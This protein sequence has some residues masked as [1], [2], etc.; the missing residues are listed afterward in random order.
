MAYDERLPQIF[1]ELAD[2]LVDDFDLIDFLVLLAERS[3]DLLGSTAVGVMLADERGRLFVA[4]STSEQ[5]RMLELFELQN[6]EGPSLEAFRTSEAVSASEIA[7]ACE[8]WP[9]FAPRA[10]SAGFQSVHA[11]PL[12]LRSDVIG[13]LNLFGPAPDPVSPAGMRLAQAMGDIATIGIMHERAIRRAGVLAEQLQ[14]ALN[15]RVIIEQA[16]GVLAARGDVDV[17]DAFQTLRG[18]ARRNRLRLS[19]VA[20]QVIDGTLSGATLRVSRGVPQRKMP[21]RPAS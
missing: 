7:A 3:M 16:K 10:L 19:D 18:Y 14:S 2:T 9:H 17:D 5:A 20:R 4:A 15:S 21:P 1:V 12:R 13:A 6:D 11:I 8:R